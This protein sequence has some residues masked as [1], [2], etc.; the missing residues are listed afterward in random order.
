MG[1]QSATTHH[2]T[3]RLPPSPV[4]QVPRLVR[5]IGIVAVLYVFL[6]SIGLMGSGFKSMGKGFAEQLIQATSNPFVG[7]FVGILTTSIVQSSSLTTSIVVGMV[8]SGALTVQGAIPIVM[9]ANIGTTVTCTIVS[10]GFIGRRRE[11]RRAFACGTVHDVFNVLCVLIFFPLEL[12]CQKAFGQGPLEW[13]AGRAAGLFVGADSTAFA[14]PVKTATE[15]LVGVLA[16]VVH[17]I[18]GKGVAGAWAQ[19]ALAFVIL[20]ACLW[21]L[22]MLMRSLMLGRVEAVLDRTVGRHAAL[23]L[24]VGLIVTAIIQSSSITTSIMIP[25]AAGGIVTLQQVFPI[26]VGAN[27]GTTVTALM[28]SLGGSPA[29][30]HIALVHLLFN[31]TGALIFVPARPMRRLPVALAEALAAMTMRSR[32]YAIVYVAVLFF[33]IPALLIFLT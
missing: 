9:G 21:S 19:V 25:L 33:L 28:A 29:G 23:G 12:A 26:T 4:Q 14:S 5:V 27:I 7:L 18:A 30:L 1:K 11:F 32:W 8:S 10:L 17:A 20:F 24:V 2:T 3:R 15:P 22:T 13:L 31:S 6:A 16:G